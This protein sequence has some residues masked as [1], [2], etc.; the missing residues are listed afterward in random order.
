MSWTDITMTQAFRASVSRNPDRDYI[1][2]MGERFSFAEFDR[3]IDRF[4]AGLLALGVKRHDRVAIWMTNCPSWVMVW[5]ATTRIGA[6]LV[7]INTRYRTGEA[8]YILEQSG[9]SVLVTMDRYWGI[10]YLVMLDEMMPGYAKQAPGKL[11]SEA[12]PALRAVVTWN[13]P[14][15]GTLGIEQVGAMGDAAA[16]AQAEK[17]VEPND[18]AIIVYTSGTTGNPKGAMHSHVI[19]RNARN[20][21]RWMHIENGDRILGHMPFYHVAGAIGC[22]CTSILVGATI[23]TMPSWEPGEALRTISG[24]KVTIFGGIPTHFIDLLDHPDQPKY[25]TTCLKSA[26]IGGANVTPEVAQASRDRLGLDSLMAVYGMTETTASTSMSRFEDPLEKACDNRGLPIGEF[27]VK[28][29]DPTTGT[30]MPADQDGE[31]W[32]RGHLVML[33]YYNNP[34]ATAEVMTPD[35]WFKTG[36]LG[37]FDKDG[38]LKITG[39]AKDMFIV[40]GSNTYPAEIERHIQLHPAVKQAAVVGVPDR[41][42]GEVGFAF[43]EVFENATVSEAEII[44]HCRGRIADYKVPRYVRVIQEMPR[45]ATNKIQKFVLAEM[46]RKEIEALARKAG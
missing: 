45:T 25:D 10:D 26:W 28:V 2:G 4:A 7:P 1:V 11:Q 3:K 9:A 15:P 42:L 37:Q 19:L 32:V 35:G 39:R 14:A 21:A 30:P 29:C 44:A 24:E 23:V 46:A 40:G 22:I 41:R 13:E 6:T 31:V 27:E 18:P 36:D 16:L 38:Y 12:L 20:M 34:K 17:L 5:L 33:G 8:Q 43:I